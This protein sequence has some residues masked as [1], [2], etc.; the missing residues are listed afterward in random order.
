M[1]ILAWGPSLW[2]LV[3]FDILLNTASLFHHSNVAIP[4]ALQDRIERLI[5]TPRMHRCHH[6]LYQTLFSSSL[7][8][9]AFSTSFEPS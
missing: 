2:G 7:A 6:A 1:M 5:V 9:T 3:T 8:M 4:M